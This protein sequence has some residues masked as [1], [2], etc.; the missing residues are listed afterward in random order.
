[1]EKEIPP[2]LRWP[3]LGFYVRMF[4]CQMTEAVEEDVGKYKSFSSLFTRSL[5]AG[6]RP[7]SREHTLVCLLIELMI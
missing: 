5:K 3:M 2:W 1:M 6:A 4:D 7:I